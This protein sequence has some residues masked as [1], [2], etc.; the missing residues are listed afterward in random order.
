MHASHIRKAMQFR[1][2]AVEHLGQNLFT[3]PKQNFLF[4]AIPKQRQSTFR[5]S[6]S[7]DKIASGIELAS[8]FARNVSR[9][10]FDPELVRPDMINKFPPMFARLL[11]SLSCKNFCTSSFLKLYEKY[12]A[13][14]ISLSF[15]CC[16]KYKKDA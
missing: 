6:R 13:K 4:L 12:F 9:T 16:S 14:F 15:I 3:V 5:G 10:R 11:A 7:A 2:V 8:T 1:P